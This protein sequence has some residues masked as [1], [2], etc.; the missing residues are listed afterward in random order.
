MGGRG[1]VEEGRRSWQKSEGTIEREGGAER[2]IVPY[3]PTP[4]MLIHLLITLIHT[5]VVWLIA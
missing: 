4:M 5:C 1:V 3:F 2:L